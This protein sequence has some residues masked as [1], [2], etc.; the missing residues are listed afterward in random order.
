MSDYV[1]R[2]GF[3]KFESQIIRNNVAFWF[4]NSHKLEL[5]TS[6]VKQDFKKISKHEV[7][8]KSLQRCRAA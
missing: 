4:L 7:H 2:D 6:K 1:D 5:H 8:L 3:E